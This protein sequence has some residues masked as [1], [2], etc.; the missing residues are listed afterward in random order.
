MTDRLEWLLNYF[1]LKANVFQAGPLCRNASFEARE[2]LGYIHVLNRGLLRIET[3]G[4]ADVVLNNPSLV[5]YMN[6][7]KHRLLPLG[8]DVDSVCASFGFGAGLRN[9]LARALPDMLVL[10]LGDMPGLG[11]SLQLLFNESDEIHC[12]RQAIMDRTIEIVIIQLLRHLMDEN[13]LQIGLL[14][15]LADTRLARAINAMHAEVSQQWTLDDLARLAGMSRARFAAKFKELVGLTPGSYM[16]EWR[17][18]VAQSLLRRGKSIQQV[19]DAVGYANASSFSRTF[20]AHVGVSP[21]R[22]LN[23]HSPIAQ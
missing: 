15:G 8:K 2:G 20:I 12:G 23:S 21:K 19:A 3:R 5:F 1:E 7:I 17:M 6:P 11:A 18:G 16:A 4:Q 10:G 22:W 13:R 9:P 14:A